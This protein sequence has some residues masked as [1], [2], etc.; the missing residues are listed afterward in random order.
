MLP[1]WNR[2]LFCPLGQLFFLGNRIASNDAMTGLHRLL[3][4]DSKYKIRNKK[5]AV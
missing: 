5:G 3:A 4:Y 2:C 1:M